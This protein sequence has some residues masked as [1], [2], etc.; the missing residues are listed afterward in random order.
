[1]I[2]STGGLHKKLREAKPL[3]SESVG[4][5]RRVAAQ[6]ATAVRAHIAVADVVAED[7]YDVWFLPLCLSAGGPSTA[8]QGCNPPMPD[9]FS[10]STSYVVLPIRLFTPAGCTA[11]PSNTLS[12]SDAT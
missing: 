1:M 5:W 2:T 7:E 12:R 6:F 3:A 9:L 10:R 11:V 4:V 8:E